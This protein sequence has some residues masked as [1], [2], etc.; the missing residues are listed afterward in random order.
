MTIIAILAGV[1]LFDVLAYRY[2]AEQRP[3]FHA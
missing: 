3:G 2:A 1:A